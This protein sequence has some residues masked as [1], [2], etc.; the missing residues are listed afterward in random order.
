[1]DSVEDNVNT[2]NVTTI[3]VLDQPSVGSLTA[4]FPVCYDPPRKRRVLSPFSVSPSI[5]FC[6]DI[7]PESGSFIKK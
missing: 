7:K 4:E 5:F 6:H 2:G 1:M 3:E